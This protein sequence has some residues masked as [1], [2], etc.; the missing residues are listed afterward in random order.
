MSDLNQAIINAL[1]NL[2]GKEIVTLDVH[3]LTDVTDTLIIA[4]GTSSRHTRSLAENLVEETKKAGFRALGVE[5]LDAGDWVLVDYGDTI[6]HV[7]QQE[8]RD[9]Y[10]LEK[11]WSMK[12][13]NRL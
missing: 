1:E 9:Y 8:A 10:E 4:S 11:L 6:V 7:M 3:E 5:G 12:P 13:A 2:K